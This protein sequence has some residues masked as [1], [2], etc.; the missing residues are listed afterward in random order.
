V[1]KAP[2]KKAAKAPAKKA[3]ATRAPLRRPAKASTS[4]GSLPVLDFPSPA[5]GRGSVALLLRIY[6]AAALPIFVV[7]SAAMP[8][9][10]K[11]TLRFSERWTA[12]S[13]STRPVLAAEVGRFKGCRSRPA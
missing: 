4:E 7:H 12:P 6:C 13:A 8:A 11:K 9:G 3:G 1:R 5:S 10:D 2:A